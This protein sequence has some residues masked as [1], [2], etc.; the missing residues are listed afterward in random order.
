MTDISTEGNAQSD[1]LVTFDGRSLREAKRLEWVFITIHAFGVPLILLM[2]WLHNPASTI[3]LGVIAGLLALGSLIAG[4]LNHRIK[5]FGG[6]KRLAVAS[7]IGISIV[8]WASILHFVNDFNTAAYAVYSLLIIEGAIRFEMRGSIAM[9]AIFMLGLLG[10][11]FFRLSVYDFRFS[12]SGYT[13]WTLIMILIAGSIGFIT[14]EANRERRRNAELIR[15]RT[16]DAERHRM[17]R[18]LHDTVLKTFQGIALETHVIAKSLD[19]CARERVMQ[20]EEECQRSSDEIRNVIHDLRGLDGEET[21]GN[22]IS[23]ILREWSNASGIRVNFK[24]KGIDRHLPGVVAYNVR[25][26]LSEALFNTQK[27]ANATQVDVLLLNTPDQMRIQI[28][29]N[30]L[31]IH[32]PDEEQSQLLNTRHSYGILGMK[33]RIEQLGGWFSIECENGT[34]LTVEIPLTEWHDDYRF[35][36]G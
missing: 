19:S 16:L 33:E 18:E 34:A 17:A 28:S 1:N 15:S 12:L 22:Q 32:V 14:R 36:S 6:Q 2:T 7:L 4:F 8:V 10:A 11:M 26:I 21:I 35:D 25:C 3:G 24:S 27:H 30:G 20:I 13:Y 23:S 29:D 9:A 31:G 5:S